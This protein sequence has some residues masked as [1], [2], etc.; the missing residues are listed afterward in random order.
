[1]TE[2]GHVTATPTARHRRLLTQLAR[3]YYLD[4][5]SKVQ[6]ADRFGLSR[7]Q[8]ARML[9]EAHDAGVVTITVESGSSGLDDRADE[10]ASRLGIRSAIIVDEG[11]SDVTTAMGRAALRYIDAQARPGQRIGLSWSRTLDA[12]ASFVPALPPSTVVQLAGALQLGEEPSRQEVFTRLGQDPAVHVTRLFA[13]LLVT[14]ADTATDLLALSEITLALQAAD[15]LDLA[16][17]SVGSWQE[18]LSSVWLKCTPAQREAATAAG[19]VAET[20]GRLIAADGSP[21]DT[22]NDRI[23]AV[24]LDQLRAAKTTV[25]VAH[26]A[27]RADAVRAATAAGIIDVM[28]VDADLAEAL[29]AETADGGGS[30]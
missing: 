1:M 6:I 14:E 27:A 26:G 19:A 2:G 28:I 13:P 18:D 16:L 21:V 3:A 22:I 25:G 10:L 4:R 30:R 9:D 29:L 23:I 7:F 17:V 15:D 20:S 12:A 11:A 8:V 24:S 5:L